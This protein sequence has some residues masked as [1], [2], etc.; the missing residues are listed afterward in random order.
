MMET[1]KEKVLKIIDALPDNCTYEEI[2]RRIYV[3]TRTN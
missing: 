3:E 2:L 1:A